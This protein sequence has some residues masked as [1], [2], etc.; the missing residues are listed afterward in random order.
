MAD[1]RWISRLP[2]G[3]PFFP[4]PLFEFGQE[5]SQFLSDNG[6]L[7]AGPARA[8]DDLGGIQFD[9]VSMTEEV[10]KAGQVFEKLVGNIGGEFQFLVHGFENRL[11]EVFS[12]RSLS[13]VEDDDACKDIL[14]TRVETMKFRGGSFHKFVVDVIVTVPFCE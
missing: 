5:V 8:V 12:F 4:D 2:S 14:G 7:E 9:S 11:V 13:G 10:S 6:P 3:F 1:Q